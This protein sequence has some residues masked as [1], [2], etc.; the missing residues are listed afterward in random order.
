[1][2]HVGGYTWAKAGGAKEYRPFYLFR[3]INDSIISLEE[4]ELEI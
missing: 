3:P 1:M 4:V 2:V